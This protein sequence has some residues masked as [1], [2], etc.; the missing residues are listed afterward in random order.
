MNE[1]KVKSQYNCLLYCSTYIVY[2]VATLRKNSHDTFTPDEDM[3]KK[4]NIELFTDSHYN[5]TTSWYLY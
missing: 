1:S 5:R 4:I 3:H 2:S